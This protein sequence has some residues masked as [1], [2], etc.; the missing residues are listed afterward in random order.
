MIWAPK[1]EVPKHGM[2]LSIL[3]SSNSWYSFFAIKNNKKQ[4]SSAWTYQGFISLHNFCWVFFETCISHH[5][6]EN[7]QI[8]GKLQILE[9]VLARQNIG[10][11]YFYSYATIAPAISP[12]APVV[13]IL[14]QVL[15]SP[16]RWPWLGILGYLYFIFY[17][18][19]NFFK[20]HDL[21]SF[22]NKISII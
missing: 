16:L 13:R 9:D 4:T 8:Y 5:G 22:V 15:L 19:C 3:A 2:P 1:F 12:I 18:I 17:M 14:L 6:C 10:C 21:C 7:F 20:C 11:R